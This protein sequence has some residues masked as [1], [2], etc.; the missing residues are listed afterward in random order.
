MLAVFVTLETA[1]S[2][3][4]FCFYVSRDAFNSLSLP[5]GVLHQI[6]DPVHEHTLRL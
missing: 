1:V 3:A 6:L 2:C 5:A 4:F